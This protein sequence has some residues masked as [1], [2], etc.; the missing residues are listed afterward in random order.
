MKKTKNTIQPFVGVRREAEGDAMK[1]KGRVKGRVAIFLSGRGSNFE[2]IY[3][4]SQQ[5]DAN[6]EIVA[7]ISDKK[8][9]KGLE[10]AK[11]LN[12]DAF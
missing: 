12:L 8:D 11:E 1:Q 5:E 2:A 3:T 10:R 9:A 4:H 6:F 7:V